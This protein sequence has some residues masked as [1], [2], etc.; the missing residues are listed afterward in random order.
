M[1]NRRCVATE[2]VL[3]QKMCCN[4]RCVA[5]EDVLPFS[6]RPGGGQGHDAKRRGE[7]EG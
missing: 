1:Q 6:P 4:R 7:P 2:D 5:T 3:Q